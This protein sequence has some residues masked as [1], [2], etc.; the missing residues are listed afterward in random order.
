M[1]NRNIS[2]LA[3]VINRAYKNGRPKPIVLLGAGASI[4]A[5]IP[6][7]NDLV[8]YINKEYK[9][10][11]TI[12]SLGKDERNYYSLMDCLPPNERRTILKSF[13]EKSKINV[14]HI[15]L[16]HL[17]N[18]GYIDYVLTTNFDDLVQR[19]LALYN[20]FPTTY[21][22]STLKDLTTT[23]LELNSIIYLHGK[24]D[25]F[26][27]LNTFE[28]MNKNKG[29]LPSIFNKIS[30]NRTWIIVGYSGEDAVFD[31]L[32]DLGRF[33]NGL[34]WLA[35][36]EPSE[37]VKDNLLNKTNTESYV[38]EGH[39]SD[40]FFLEL[41]SELN[42]SVPNI[43]NKPFSFLKKLHSNIAEIDYKKFNGVKENL[44]RVQV[45]IDDAIKKYEH[46]FDNSRLDSE[47]IR[48]ITIE[49]NLSN[50]LLSRDYDSAE[51]VLSSIDTSEYEELKYLLYSF[52]NDWG[53][54]EA[55]IAAKSNDSKKFE[56][57]YEKFKKAT[58]I[59]EDRYEAWANWGTTI[60]RQQQLNIDKVTKD[61]L[62]LIFDKF[63]HAVKYE[64]NSFEVWLDWANYTSMYANLFENKEEIIKHLEEA[65]RKYFKASEIKDKNHLLN[66]NWGKCLGTLASIKNDTNSDSLYK[67]A[68][69]RL[70]KAI[71]AEPNFEEALNLLG[72]AY[73]DY[74]KHSPKEKTKKLLIKSISIYSEMAESFKEN[75]D[76]YFLTISY[77]YFKLWLIENTK[78]IKNEYLHEGHNYLESAIKEGVEVNKIL[79]DEDWKEIRRKIDTIDRM[80]VNI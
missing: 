10:S 13:V 51:E 17:I 20:V 39:D 71:D 12:N 69:N 72:F 35:Y 36:D 48:S 22:L 31:S 25:G 59:A 65:S 40:S 70:K 42:N 14:T 61:N 8:N 30:N 62:E 15:Y 55:E 26:W 56:S 23:S 33:D 74:A 75:S 66:Y 41:N 24:Y 54:K 46:I 63:E 1:K 4:S 58:E 44:T 18:T 34:Y 5:N 68:I 52:Y 21:D 16:A 43:F 9:D 77:I 7:A 29:I 64:A 28:E 76:T 57:A 49:K 27:Q 80:L 11:P 78:T 79:N 6:S 45:L 37:R 53:L 60:G 47:K 67:H 19:A 73:M 50:I 32:V 3:Y 2:D 38:I